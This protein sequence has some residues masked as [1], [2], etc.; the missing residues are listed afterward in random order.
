MSEDFTI[1][2]RDLRRAKVCWR[3]GGRPFLLRHKLDP[4]VFLK[5]GI[6]A[7]VLAATDDAVA[8]RVVDMARDARNGR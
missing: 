6:S 1:H 5:R 3:N 8:I 2:L 4:R 7:N